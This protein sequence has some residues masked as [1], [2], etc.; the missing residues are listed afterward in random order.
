MTIADIKKMYLAGK[1]ISA[2]N[3][4]KNKKYLNDLN[5]LFSLD[6]DNTHLLFYMYVYDITGIPSCD[7]CKKRK[8]KFESMN[9]GFKKHCGDSSCAKKSR[10]KSQSI[11]WKSKDKDKIVKKTQKTNLEKYGK[12]SNLSKGTDSRVHAI[13]KMIEKYGVNHPSKSSKIQETKKK[14]NLKKWGTEHTLQSDVVRNKIEKT[15]IKK[16]GVKTIGSSKELTEKGRATQIKNRFNDLNKRADK[17]NIELFYIDDVY[18]V[19][20]KCKVCSNTYNNIHRLTINR[21][22]ASGETFC[23]KC[24]PN[25]LNY[26][27]RGEM[28]IADFLTDYGI[29]FISNKKS[30][31]NNDYEVDIIIPSKKLGIEFNGLY[32]HS[33]LNKGQKYHS[34]KKIH[35][36]NYGYDIINIWEDDW[37]DPIKKS[38]IKSKLK[39][40]LGIVK[41]KIGARSCKI[42][43]INSKEAKI[44]LN[45]NH[46]Y[47]YVNSKVKLGLYYKDELVS[48]MT[49]GKPRSFVSGKSSKYEWEMLRFAT[50][51]DLVVV[52]GISK[53]INFFNKHYLNVNLISYADCDW[54]GFTSKSYQNAGF[55]LIK[56][57]DPGYWWVVNGYRHNRFNYTRWKLKDIKKSE[58]VDEYMNERGHYKVWNTGNLLFEFIK[59]NPASL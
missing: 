17:I 37:N 38:I 5:K 10:A 32:W 6:S 18:R 42:K 54:Y 7:F 34:N 8:L 2:M 47:G 33:E 39:V 59:Y 4:L 16:W 26:R 48:V 21:A 1:R 56:K 52:G 55:N 49:F 9:H 57:T 36:S 51:K 58:T 31:F 43:K 23:T 29:E 14:N 45:N 13:N 50:K 30:M 22:I 28:E 20:C 3:F 41:S 35:C 12:P 25:I 46:L 40:K 44:F 19:N 24:N 11:A 27:S 53:F 15:N